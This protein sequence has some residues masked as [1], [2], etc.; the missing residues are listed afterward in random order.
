MW[1]FTVKTVLILIGS[2]GAACLLIYGYVT[3]WFATKQIWRE[4]AQDVTICPDWLEIL[5]RPSLNAKHHVQHVY[6]AIEGYEPD[7]IAPFPIRLKDGSELNPEVQVLDEYG[8]VYN[9]KWRSLIGSL[10]GFGADF[11]RDRLYTSV[12]IR[13]DKS[14]R[15]STVYWECARLK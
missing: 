15:C 7:R 1:S 10:V 3:Y 8:Q 14:F 5:P 9:L 12:R 13:C 11:P 2:L 4:L 6:L